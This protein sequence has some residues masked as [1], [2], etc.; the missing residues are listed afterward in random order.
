MAVYTTDLL[1]A[2]HRGY[3]SWAAFADANT[4]PTATALIEMR[5][6][7][8]AIVNMAYHNSE[9]ASTT[10]TATLA[11]YEMVVIDRMIADAHLIDRGEPVVGKFLTDLEFA[12]LRDL[13]DAAGDTIKS[14]SMYDKTNPFRR[15]ILH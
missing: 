15:G 13:G 14:V 1:Y 3:D 12:L 11:Q 7:A 2:N 5:K 9:T 10:H 4:I 8:H 6:T